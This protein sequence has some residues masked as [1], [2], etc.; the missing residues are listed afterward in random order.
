VQVSNVLQ[1]HAAALG[2]ED[3]DEDG[4]DDDDD[5]DGQARRW[6]LDVS[7]QESCKHLMS[8]RQKSTRRRPDAGTK[9]VIATASF[10]DG[11]EAIF[12]RKNAVE[13]L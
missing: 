13:G 11:S 6:R 12:V 7:Y 8:T 10:S 5:D 1:C 4:D 3:D 2:N 9:P